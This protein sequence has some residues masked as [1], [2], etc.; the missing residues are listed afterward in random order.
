M[1]AVVE[2]HNKPNCNCWNQNGSPYHVSNMLL[3]CYNVRFK[4]LKCENQEIYHLYQLNEHEEDIK[5]VSKKHGIQNKIKEYIDDLINDRNIS[6]PKKIHI[7]LS[8]KNIL[9]P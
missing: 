8:G 6:M 1:A 9:K 2:K 3:S 4:I 5:L 7:K